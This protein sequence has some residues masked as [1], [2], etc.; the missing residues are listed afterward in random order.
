MI[1][2]CIGILRDVRGDG[3]LATLESNGVRAEPTDAY[4]PHLR[5]G[6]RFPASS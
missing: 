1:D 5:D 6:R 3:D 4:D 2:R